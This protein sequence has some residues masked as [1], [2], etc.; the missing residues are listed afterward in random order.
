MSYSLGTVTYKFFGIITKR[1]IVPG[2]SMLNH[3][4]TVFTME[5][6]SIVANGLTTTTP[7][8]QIQSVCNLRVELKHFAAILQLETSPLCE[9]L[10][11][12]SDHPIERMDMD[13]MPYEYRG[14]VS[15]LEKGAA[16]ASALLVA[17]LR[18]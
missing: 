5:S 1:R 12:P 16:G 17:Q 10:I 15:D 13:G 2:A 3:M 6:S 11:R 14:V 9:Q 4:T 7:F 8:V 18:Q